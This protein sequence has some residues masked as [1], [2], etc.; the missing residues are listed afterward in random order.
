MAKVD[1][2]IP[3]FPGVLLITL[4]AG[5]AV[6]ADDGPGVTLDYV[7][8]PLTNILDTW[9][10]GWRTDEAMMAVA[11]LPGPAKTVADGSNL[12]A[13]HAVASLGHVKN[14][15]TYT[16]AAAHPVA[17]AD[18]P[19]VRLNLIAGAEVNNLLAAERA[20]QLLVYIGPSHRGDLG[21][22]A[23]GKGGQVFT[24]NLI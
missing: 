8:V 17:P 1:A 23:F 16:F 21:G 2:L 9:C 7:R 14:G 4:E 22:R 3:G 24:A 20:H 10:A 6:I 15:G 12:A 11:L 19:E 13:P 5:D 18:A